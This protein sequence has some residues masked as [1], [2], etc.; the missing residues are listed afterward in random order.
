[1]S[2]SARY[3]G[4]DKAPAAYAV[5]LWRRRRAGAPQVELRRR[6]FFSVHL[7]DA[8]H[9]YCFL[10]TRMMPDMEAKFA[11]ELSPGARAYVCDFPLPTKEPV[12]VVALVGESKL[13]KTLYVYQY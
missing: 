5:A 11:R 4:V 8:S 12:E 2:R 7:G 6:N 13:G 9:V 1:M 3:I 10:M